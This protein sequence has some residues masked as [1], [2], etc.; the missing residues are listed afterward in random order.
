[1]SK[2]RIFLGGFGCLALCCALGGAV[3]TPAHAEASPEA[4]VKY[5]LTVKKSGAGTGTVTSS[6]GGISCA[7][8][9]S[10]SYTKGTSV[11]LTEVP[12]V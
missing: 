2:S 5:K 6:P 1:M 3:S 10:A 11:N 7:S 12:L 9:C 8:T 4:T